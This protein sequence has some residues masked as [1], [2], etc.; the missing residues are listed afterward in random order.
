MNEGVLSACRFWPGLLIAL[1]ALCPGGSPCGIS[2]HIE[3]GE[4][5]RPVMAFRAPH[6]SERLRGPSRMLSWPPGAEGRWPGLWT[7]GVGSA[8]GQEA[9][10][11]VLG[12]LQAG[13]SD[14]LGHQRHM[15]QNHG[16]EGG[17]E[18]W[19]RGVRNLCP[20]YRGRATWGHRSE[21][22]GLG[23]F[24]GGQLRGGQGNKGVCVVPGIR[25]A[26]RDNRRR[27]Q[28]GTGSRCPRARGRGQRYLDV[29]HGGPGMWVS[30][31]VDQS[32]VSMNEEGESLVR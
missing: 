30:R 6:R 22:P 1:G 8:E 4:C 31:D 29:G 10:G 3:I 32:C 13:K 28:L 12:L 11:R 21:S 25:G 20:K 27:G 15:K 7:V 16:G 2:T 26:W 17:S 18:G 23:G 9:G 24:K 14:Q 5:Q 19:T